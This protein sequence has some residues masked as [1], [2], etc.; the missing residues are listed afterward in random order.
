MKDP[1]TRRMADLLTAIEFLRSYDGAPDDP[2]G[3]ACSRVADRLQKDHDALAKA[4]L[5][6]ILARRYSRTPTEIR[7]GLAKLSPTPD[8]IQAALEEET[9]EEAE[10]AKEAGKGL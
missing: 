10:E 6:R 5:V 2:N 4:A 9:A 7:A 1:D 8:L 3:P